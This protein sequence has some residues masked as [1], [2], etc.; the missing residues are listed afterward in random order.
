MKNKLIFVIIGIC[1]LMI[2]SMF[3]SKFKNSKIEK[4]TSNDNSIIENTE[5]N[6]YIIYD[7]SGNVKA[8]T[9]NIKEVNFYKEY[10]D[11]DPKMGP[12]DFELFSKENEFEAKED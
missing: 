1:L 9:N 11:Y 6:E 3:I 10:P 8:V 2:I 5:N 12:D 4:D 7:G